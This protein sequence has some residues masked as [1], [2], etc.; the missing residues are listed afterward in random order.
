MKYEIK[1]EL[2]NSKLVAPNEHNAIAN[3]C[4]HSSIVTRFLLKMLEN[5]IDN[6][7]FEL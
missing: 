5:G 7:S 3:W 2:V 1:L 4:C 6:V